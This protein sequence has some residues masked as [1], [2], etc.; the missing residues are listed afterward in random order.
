MALKILLQVMNSIYMKKRKYYSERTGLVDH[1]VDLKH[2][3]RLFISSYETLQDKGFFQEYFGYWC[4][5]AGVVH[6]KLSGDIDSVIYRNI[7]KDN[8]WPIKEKI[9]S[10]KEDDLFD[11]IEFLH[12]YVSEPLSGQYHSYDNCGYHYNKFKQDSGQV[13]YRT[14]INNLLAEYMDGYE[15]NENGEIV[16]KIEPGFEKLFEA[17]LPGEDV[18]NVTRKVE[19]AALKYRRYGSSLEERREA[20]R[21]LADVLEYL[22]PQVKS[23]LES[24]QD[25]SELFN[26]AN[27]F[28]IRHH[29]KQQKNNYNKA[30]WYSWMFYFYLASIH[31]FS[32]LIEKNKK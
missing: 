8:L 23:V 18:E 17:G 16:S 12:D 32:R 25:D 19:R 7:R 22:K 14:D 4:V 20:I 9:E 10:Y 26:I 2:L 15:I 1:S 13:I 27:N 24:K 11:M 31:A 28:A 5:D 29:N 30:I 21:D 3:K 6:G